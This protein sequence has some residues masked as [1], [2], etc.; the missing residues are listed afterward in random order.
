MQQHLR[1]SADLL[2]Q[3]AHSLFHHHH[4]DGSPYPAEDCPNYR[5]LHQCTPQQEHEDTFWRTDGNPI[6]V[7]NFSYPI[8]KEDGSCTGAVVHFHDISAQKT[9][10]QAQRL[11]AA[12]FENA[13]EGIIIT[14]H[15]GQILQVNQAFCDITGYDSSDAIGHTPALLSSGHHDQH[16][17]QQLWQSLQEQGRW[18]GEIINR[19]KNG[20]LYPEWLSITS[21]HNEQGNLSHYIG[22]F[23]DITERKRQEARI[24]HLAE[25]DALTGLPNR[26][27]LGESFHQLLSLSLRD[28]DVV[29]RLGGD[30]F[31]ILLP[32]LDSAR[33]AS[34]VANKV[35]QALSDDFSI[36]HHQL[37][38]SFSIGIALAPNDGRDFSLLLRHADNA[39]YHAKSSGRNTF[40]FFNKHMNESA[41]IR[42]IGH[43]VLETACQQLAD[44]N[45]QGLPLDKLAVNVK[46]RPRCH[47]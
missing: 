39:M 2:G 14:D 47:P 10:Q 21:V 38:T 32:M 23:S 8:L 25:H 31:I 45:R 3:H 17:Y 19:R 34:Q 13:G 20:E 22:V 5:T 7:T 12:V 15:K 6:T 4:A 16:F 40:R 27:Q 41:H 43:W 29:G 11:A 24:Q 35:L 33:E 42:T 30:E 26:T 18:C 37:H 9:Q 1:Q 36:E 46:L 44:W 28:S